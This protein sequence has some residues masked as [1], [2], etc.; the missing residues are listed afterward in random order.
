MAT[1]FFGVLLMFKVASFL[2][3]RNEVRKDHTTKADMKE[4]INWTSLNVLGMVIV[5]TSLHN[6]L[7]SINGEHR[8]HIGR[9]L[10]N[11]QA[12]D[13]GEELL[14]CH[15]WIICTKSQTLAL[16]YKI[17]IKKKKGVFGGEKWQSNRD[18]SLLWPHFAYWTLWILTNVIELLGFRNWK[19]NFLCFF[20]YFSFY[21]L[22]L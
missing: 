2:R 3:K 9:Q 11:F 5:E 10:L 12:L 15:L 13:F 4:R 22:I 16:K 8:F 14:H 1:M 19:R 20:F 21:F 7:G 17:E 6:L 18:R